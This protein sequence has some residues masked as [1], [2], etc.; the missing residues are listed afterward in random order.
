VHARH[1]SDSGARVVICVGGLFGYWS[2]RLVRAPRLVRA[3]RLEWLWILVQQP[4][5]WRRYTTGIAT[6]LLTVV[7]MR[8]EA[9]RAAY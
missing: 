3:L 9:R 7:R 4:H 2:G 8:L 5:K 1:R 6:F